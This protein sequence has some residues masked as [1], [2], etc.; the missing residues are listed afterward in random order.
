MTSNIGEAKTVEMFDLLIQEENIDKRRE[1]ELKLDR[2]KDENLINNYSFFESVY[3]EVDS[4]MFFNTGELDEYIE[5]LNMKRRIRTN[6]AIC[7]CGSELVVDEYKGYYES[8]KYLSCQNEKCD[9][10]DNEEI[11]GDEWK[12]AYA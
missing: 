5:E 11:N 6:K 12:G 2:L 10:L 9:F 3:L 1:L 7:A 4:E 8:F